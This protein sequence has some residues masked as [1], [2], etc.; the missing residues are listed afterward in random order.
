LRGL[1]FDAQDN[2]SAAVADY[3][4]LITWDSVF[5]Y[6]FM[7]DVLARM[8]TIQTARAEA[9]ATAQTATQ[10]V[11]DAT[12]TIS[13]ERTASFQ[14]TV[15]A[16]NNA[17]ATLVVNLTE[18]VQAFEALNAT[19]TATAQAT[20]NPNALAPTLPPTWTPTP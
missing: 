6:P 17:N 7:D 9:T 10:T 2:D 12:A 5:D 19:L 14:G 20:P 18:T 16:M 13:A 15:Q 8:Q 4:W 3:E 11:L 1:I